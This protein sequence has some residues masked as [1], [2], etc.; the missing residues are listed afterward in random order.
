MEADAR[1]PRKPPAERAEPGERRL[2]VVLRVA[3]DRGRDER[4]GDRPAPAAAP[5]RTRAEPRPGGRAAGARRRREG[6]PRS[7]R[8]RRASAASC[9]AS[10]LALD[11]E[12]EARDEDGQAGR[13]VRVEE[14]VR[15]DGGGR[16]RLD[17][18][19]LPPRRRRRRRCPAQ[20]RASPRWSWTSALRG[21]ERGELLDPV[22]GSP[23]RR[24]TRR[25]ACASSES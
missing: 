12:R 9:S 11:A 5:P 2:R 14:V 25:R 21:I 23:A 18:A 7:V 22:D 6:D 24:R 8:V 20:K 13:E 3:A 1:E 17:V 16:V 15:A 10:E 4:V 19:R